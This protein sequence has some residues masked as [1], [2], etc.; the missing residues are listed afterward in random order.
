M[1]DNFRFENVGA[2]PRPAC[3]AACLACDSQNHIINADDDMT[4]DDQIGQLFSRG[5]QLIRSRCADRVVIDLQKVSRA[6]T[7]L[8]A[9]LVVLYQVARSASIRLELCVSQAVLDI[10][11]ICRLDWWIK[12]L[13]EPR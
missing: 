5:R 4:S 7:K 10:A 11:T 8:I 12:R 6:D 3:A 2:I 9:C 13:A 1:S